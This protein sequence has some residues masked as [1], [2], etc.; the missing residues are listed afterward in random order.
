LTGALGLG[1]TFAFDVVA[2]LD[3]PFATG[4]AAGRFA[5][6][7]LAVDADLRLVECFCAGFRA[8]G[9]VFRDDDLRAGFTCFFAM[10]ILVR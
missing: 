3:P 5:G 8:A 10:V 2:R 4:L 1:A 9:R 6:A 7:R